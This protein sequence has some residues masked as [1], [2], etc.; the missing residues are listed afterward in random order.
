MSL[1]VGLVAALFLALASSSA[2]TPVPSPVAPPFDLYEI[3]PWPDGRLEFFSAQP[4]PWQPLHQEKVD[5]RTWLLLALPDGSVATDPGGERARYLGRVRDGERVILIAPP[6]PGTARIRTGRSLSIAPSG[7]TVV[8]TEEA[9]GVLARR[10]H[11]GF[12]ELE[13][14]LPVPR[15]R[16][17]APPARLAEILDQARSSAS[18][19]TEQDVRDVVNRVR[20]DSLENYVRALSEDPSGGPTIRWWE[21]PRT[22]GVHTDYIVAKFQ[23]A[24]GDSETVAVFQHGFDVENDDEELVRVYNIIGKHESPVP[25]AGAVL[26]TAHMDAVG[27]RSDPVA[28]CEA[29]YTH[30]GCDCSASTTEILLDPDCEWDA[31][32]DPSPGADDNATG[33]AALIE[34]ARLLAPLTFDFDIYFVAFQAEEIGLIGS[35]AFADSVVDADQEIWAVL[36]MDMLGYNASINELDI[37]TDES[38]EWF[39]DWLVETGQQFVAQLPLEKYVEPF[40]R[41]DHASFW[42]RGI[43]AVGVLEDIELPYP[44]YHSY[45]DLWET[46]FPAAGRPNPELQFQLGVQLAV[47]SMARLSVQYTAPDLAIPAGE[48]VARSRI[49]SL[50]TIAGIDVFLTARVHNFGSSSLTFLD[51]TTDSLTARVSFYDGDPDAGGTLIGEITRRDFFGSG[52]VVPFELIWDT[53][54]V[55]IGFHEVFAVV[56]GLDVGYEQLE[57]SPGNNRESDTFFLEAARDA[58]P[59]IL[60][61]YTYPNPARGGPSEFTF[62]YEL[63]RDAGV[64]LS[65]YDLE[66]TEVARFGTG[67]RFFFEG[68][69]AGANAVPGDDVIDVDLESG[70]YLYVLRVT[71]DG[72]VTDEVKGKFAV[73]R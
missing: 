63:S 26:L 31:T 50:G 4:G 57:I 54:D 53:T 47:A 37:V 58:E 34:A 67:E 44:G 49:P 21:D 20:I 32:T 46:M 73:V 60:E 16:D 24:L 5:G 36:N 39:A 27:R 72:T 62:Y 13:R 68:N 9:R 69:Q 12:R 8:V 66:G 18:A 7:A 14:P 70:V 43:D 6:Q 15:P 25:G 41:S 2:A 59:R 30:A 71:S 56:E 23:A 29:G 40:G 19:R 28:L 45:D 65:V 11:A 3:G 61:H 52:A 1:R 38:S 35:A 42:A 55:G 48:M 33:V 22:R 51:E 17:A 64:I 10:A